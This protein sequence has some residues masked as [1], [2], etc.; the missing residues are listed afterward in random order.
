M[1][2]SQAVVM[3]NRDIVQPGMWRAAAGRNI[4][5]NWV[6]W[7]F[8]GARGVRAISAPIIATI[9]LM[10][11][12]G[13]GSA[14][15]FTA[16]LTVHPGDTES[17]IKVD[18]AYPQ[19]TVIWSFRNT[20]GRILGLGERIQD[21][22]LVDDKGA[23]VAV[24]KVGP[25]EYTAARA[26]SHFSYVVRLGQPASP[27]DTAHISALNGQYGL[28]MLADLLPQLET[29]GV[30]LSVDVPPSWD[31]ASSATK[32]AAGAYSV[33]SPG[34]GVFLIGSGLRET[35]K[36][37]GTTDFDLVTAGDWPFAG[38]EVVR[39]AAK[40]IKH[41]S[42]HIGFELTGRVVLMLTPFAGGFGS[43]RWSAETHGANLVVVMGPNSSAR[44]LLG[45][46]S[47]VLAHELFHL[48]VPNALSLDGDY[49]WFFE[50]FTL[51]EAL[52]TAVHLGFIDFQE[53]L[54]T[55]G[56]VYD[57]Y[58]ATSDRDTNSL[59]EASRRRWTGGSSLVYDK[60]MLLAFLYDLE[61]RTASQNRRSLDGIYHELFRR[62]PPGAKR[63]EGN[64]SIVSILSQL[65]GDG[66]FDKRYIVGPAAIN[67]E[68]I[69]PDYG[70]TV[71]D[72]GGRK[73]LLVATTLNREQDD[74]L[75]ALG[76]KKP[77]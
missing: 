19:G 3:R 44:S 76:Y 35:R 25:G 29:S 23:L 20:Y 64:E 7:T 65:D 1:L 48:W 77:R 6:G 2:T 73:R 72:S 4:D 12:S 43:E 39:I 57:S 40:I 47:V 36:R 15:A 14:Q 49:D 31:I 52:C 70:M 22:S 24:R 45:R 71:I 66:R 62:F 17:T 9:L 10:L 13:V 41:H 11:F 33:P 55:I 28:L 42:S 61:L 5:G 74:L 46:L 37:V 69:L 16:R 27:G 21:L 51:Y 60:G 34:N 54:N 68:T 18:G 53:Y 8:V 67:L 32:I 59:V 75:H 56:R 58:L 50:G 38:D 30:R 26:A 63:A